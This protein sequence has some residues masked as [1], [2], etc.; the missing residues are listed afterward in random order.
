MKQAWTR[1]ANNILKQYKD[2]LD[3]RL[4]AVFLRHHQN[5]TEI[6][7]NRAGEPLAAVYVSPVG[8]HQEMFKRVMRE[9]RERMQYACDV[10]PPTREVK[11]D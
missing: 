3:E 4:H 2:H 7:L 1:L 8:S 10:E 9:I 11:D 6:V 5:A